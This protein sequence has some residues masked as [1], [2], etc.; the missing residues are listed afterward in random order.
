MENLGTLRELQCTL[1]YLQTIERELA[2]LPPD[3]AAL[4]AR[5]KELERQRAE[6]S[7]A[8]ELSQAQIQ[9]K[10]KE[11]AQAVKEEDH[12]RAA[13]KTTNQKVQYTAAIRELDEK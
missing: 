6:K 11:L 1:D 10:T 3:L 8:L 13:L 5:V 4:D 2:L 9:S 12:A 7:K